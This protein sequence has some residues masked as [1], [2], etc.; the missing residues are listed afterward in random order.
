MDRRALERLVEGQGR[1]NAA[2]PSRQHRLASSGRPR[3][4]QVVTAGSRHFE[5]A[6]GQELSPD[7]RQVA[8]G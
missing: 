3:E 4:Q 5:R 8:V 1:Q 7:L 2:Q 6:P